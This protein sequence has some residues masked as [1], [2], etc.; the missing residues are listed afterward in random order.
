MG[1]IIFMWALTDAMQRKSMAAMAST[2]FVGENMLGE[3]CVVGV[4]EGVWKD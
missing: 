2:D 4:S 1:V 3:I